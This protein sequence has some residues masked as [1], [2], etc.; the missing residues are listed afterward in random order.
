MAARHLE[1][2][3]VA[4]D[5]SPHSYHFDPGGQFIR[6]SLPPSFAPSEFEHAVLS[7]SNPLL[8]AAGKCT[9]TSALATACSL[10][11]WSPSGEEYTLCSPTSLLVFNLR[12]GPCVGFDM[13][14]MLTLYPQL[15]TAKTATPDHHAH[16]M[17]PS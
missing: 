3:A 16:L 14:A 1:L 13:L 2:L 17:F 10:V 6:C 5:V 9:Y 12:N 15:T 8:C 7:K 11:R 4:I